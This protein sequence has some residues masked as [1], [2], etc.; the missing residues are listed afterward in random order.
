MRLELPL[1]LPGRVG[2]GTFYHPP[3]INILL[4]LCLPGR[5]RVSSHVLTEQRRRN[6]I[7][8]RFGTLRYAE[9]R[10]AVSLVYPRLHAPCDIPV[11]ASSQLLGEKKLKM[12][13]RD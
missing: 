2:L 11:V 5:P 1:R 4:C 7:N 12:K 13:P 10:V 9:C 6:R 8:D 3:S